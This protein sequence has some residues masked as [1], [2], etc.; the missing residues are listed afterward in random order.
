MSGSQHIRWAPIDR[1]ETVT[2]HALTEAELVTAAQTDRRAFAILYRRHVEEIYRYCY[3]RLGSKEAAEDAT[4]LVFIKALEA[5][6]R[7][8]AGSFRGWLFRIA[9]NVVADTY[10]AAR[11]NSSLSPAAELEDAALGPEALTLAS[12]TAG[13]V[14]ALLA[15]LPRDQRHVVELRL[16]GLTDAEIAHTLGRSHGSVRTA[17]YRALVR[18]RGVVGADAELE[19]TD[20]AKR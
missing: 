4:S 10:R 11:P 2:D 12:E 9:H 18:L 15:E 17:M 16:A 3:R 6:P 19:V 1:Q 5:L 8:R 14:R 13:S 20:R 7:Y